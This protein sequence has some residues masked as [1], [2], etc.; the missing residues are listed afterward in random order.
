MKHIHKHPLYWFE[1]RAWLVNA[2]KSGLRTDIL[3]SLLSQLS[4]MLDKH[5]KVFIYRFDLHVDDFTSTNKIISDFN[6]RL[7]KRIKNHYKVTRIG[8]C[9]VR[10]HERV[11]RQHYHY[12]LMLDG[13][14]VNSPHNLQQWISQLW[15]YEGSK[16]HLVRYHNI[17]RDD[18]NAIN[19]ASRHLSYLAKPR[20]KGYKPPQTKDYGTSRLSKE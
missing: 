10:E 20:G 3:R 16:V 1:D 17:K 4:T 12:A 11:K 15:E 18:G 13:S 5:R 6:R 2:Q 19:K 9:W 14:K 7:F 8:Y